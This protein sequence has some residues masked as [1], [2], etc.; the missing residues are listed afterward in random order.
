MLKQLA[1]ET[2]GRAF[3]VTDARELAE[4]LPGHLGRARPA[5]TRSP[6]RRRTRSATAPGAGS[7]CG[8]SARTSR[9]APSRV[10]TVRPDRRATSEP[11]NSAM[12]RLAWLPFALYAAAAAAY[13]AHFSRPMSRHAAA[14][15]TALLGGAVA[16]PHLPHRHADDGGGLRAAGRHDRG[17]L[18]VRLAARPRLS[19][20]RADD[21]RA[22]HGGVRHGAAGGA[23][24]P[25]GAQPADRRAS[26]AA[27]QPAVHRSTCCR[28][29]SPTPA[30][31]SPSC[32]ASPTC[33]CSRRSRRSTS[34][35]STRGC[36]SLQTL[37]AMNGRAIVVGWLFLT[38]GLVVGGVWA[39]QI[40]GSPDPRAQAMSRG[41]SRRSSWRCC[42]GPCIRS[43]CSRGARSAGA[44]AAPPGC[45]RSAFVIVLLNFVPVGY[46]LTRSHNF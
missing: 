15:A 5:S 17:G 18:G 38:C 33:C 37:D 29:C 42:R 19:L 46:F 45:R 7:R 6:T 9:R 16:R 43:R 40:G 20:R 35:S 27:A 25:A 1:T 3:F 10:I 8:C 4:D 26:G 36:P 2:G 21:R 34:G 44:G 39:T 32:S 30:S 11:L 13:L 28:C 22:R 23:G 31:R 41:R 24:D 14:L 12:T